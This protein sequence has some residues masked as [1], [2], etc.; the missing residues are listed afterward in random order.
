MQLKH[1]MGGQIS[2]LLLLSVP[3]LAL[4][5]LSPWSS[6]SSSASQFAETA[7]LG[8]VTD[9]DQSKGAAPRMTSDALA[10][11]DLSDWRYTDKSVKSSKSEKSKKSPKSKKSKKS[12]K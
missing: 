7:T 6:A 2:G 1:L 8:D 11:E 4:L 5:A 10:I 3:V 9:G 12:N